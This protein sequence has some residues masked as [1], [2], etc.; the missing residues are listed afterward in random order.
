MN[1]VATPGEFASG[2]ESP[3]IIGQ[4]SLRNQGRQIL[5]TE[6]VTERVPSRFAG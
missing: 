1:R 2:E 5:P 6:S 3:N 4:D